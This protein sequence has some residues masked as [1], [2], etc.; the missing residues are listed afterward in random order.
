MQQR[1]LRRHDSVRARFDD[2]PIIVLVRCLLTNLQFTAHE[3]G[4]YVSGTVPEGLRNP[5]ARNAPDG[6][7]G[8]DCTDLGQGLVNQRPA[9]AGLRCFGI[10]RTGGIRNTIVGR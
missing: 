6:G 7:Y 1:V 9:R 5:A 3:R 10:S 4:G 8:I 2:D